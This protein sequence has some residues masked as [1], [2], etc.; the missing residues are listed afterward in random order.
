M[1][2]KAIVRKLLKI[3]GKAWERRDPEMIITI[4]AKNAT[5][6]ERAFEKPF[7]GHAGIKKYWT[8]KVVGEQEKI[9]FKLLNVYVDGNMAVVEWDAKFYDKIKKR[10][11]HLRSVAVIEIKK[12]KI[13]S[14]REYWHS[15][16][17]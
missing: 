17:H 5:Y 10:T 1:V 9:K 8:D 6:A 3:Y 2:E 11:T 4:F 15:K 14:M 13:T 12:N 7:K 16:H